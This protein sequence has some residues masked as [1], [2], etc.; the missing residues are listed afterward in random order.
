MTQ[1]VIYTDFDGTI[2]RTEGA[3]AVNSPFYQSL[4]EGYVP[5]V[6]Q[7]YKYTKMKSAEEIQKL[8]IEQFG[9]YGESIDF[10]NP[11]NNL[12]MTPHAVLFFHELINNNQISINIVTRN[13]PEYIKA[14]FHYQGFS[15]S[16]IERLN[17]MASG[18]KFKEVDN[19]L[20]MRHSSDKKP[21]CIYI[22]DD[23]T[24]DYCEM[25]RAAGH[26]DY[27]SEHI[28]GFNQKPGQFDW[29][30][31]LEQ[32]KEFLLKSVTP[33]ETSSISQETSFVATEATLNTAPSTDQSD[34][35][36]KANTPH[37]S[38]DE[39]INHS[40]ANP[41][42][43]Q[44]KPS[45]KEI[46]NPLMRLFA[47]WGF[48]IGFFVG[49]ALV[50]SGLFV[51]FGFSLLGGLILGGVL[52]FHTALVTGLVGLI[53]DIARRP[54][55]VKEDDKNP[56]NAVDNDDSIKSLSH[57]GG[58]SP[59]TQTEDLVAHFPAVFAAHNAADEQLRLSPTKSVPQDAVSPG[60]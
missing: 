4:L 7:H 3:D 11:D 5:G 32:I 10:T 41:D 35:E 17:I 30:S 48:G 44:T 57:L 15:A 47:G 59:K 24:N 13:R 55:R 60:I 46:S 45:S 39:R 53:T 38:A 56:D 23:H 26:N 6:K 22:L 27:K 49:C 37:S 58:Q 34:E 19:D 52:G 20:K 25:I 54:K 16:E 33:Q 8:F 21:S 50:A 43:D 28:H 14:L 2:T 40:A 12:L 51:P 18:Y 42:S 9:D 29:L 31:Y 36:T 1:V